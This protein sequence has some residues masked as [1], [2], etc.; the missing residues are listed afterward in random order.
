MGFKYSQCEGLSCKS[1][2]GVSG[3]APLEFRMLQLKPQER[4]GEGCDGCCSKASL[5]GWEK[6]QRIWGADPIYLHPALA[7]SKWDL[8]PSSHIQHLHGPA[9]HRSVAPAP[10]AVPQSCAHGPDSFQPFTSRCLG[11]PLRAHPPILLSLPGRF[12]AVSGRGHGAREEGVSA[13]RWDRGKAGACHPS[14]HPDPSPEQLH[15]L[16]GALRD[17]ESPALNI[18]LLPAAPSSLARRGHSLHP[19]VTAPGPWIHT[20]RRA[21]LPW[22]AGRPPRWPP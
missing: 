9:Q 5:L 6:S 13:S 14:F 15:I 21:A 17:P 4:Q 3:R 8:L 1:G 20:C 7:V 16:P 11:V 12:F 10:A 22:P 18:P 2:L 19:P